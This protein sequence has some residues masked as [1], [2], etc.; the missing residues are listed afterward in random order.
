MKYI[1]DVLDSG[2][3][4]S[5]DFD[6][7]KYVQKLESQIRDFTGAQYAVAV[8]SGTSALYASLAVLDLTGNKIAYPAFTF[9]ATLN[10]ILAHSEL[11]PVP[12]DVFKDNVTIR[13]DNF[14][15]VECA[16]PVH[17]YGHVAYMKQLKET[18]TPFIIEDCC[19]ALGSY[20]DNKHVGLFGDLGC[21][22][23]YPSKI[24]NAGEGGAVITNSKAL[25]DKLKL[26]RNHGKECWG[27]N[28]RLSEIHACLAVEQF[29]NINALLQV[30]RNKAKAWAD[31]FSQSE[32]ITR[33]YSRNGEIRNN[34][35]FTIASP[36]RALIQIEHPSSRIYYDYTLGDKPNANE[37]SK[38]VLSFP[39]G[40]NK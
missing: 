11:Q 40:G 14:P 19:Q 33:F 4:T 30:R 10:A 31:M 34:Q 38:T 7:G 13:T 20:L 32:G 8:N 18:G 2:L 28:L 9:K 22:S 17:L 3:L 23:F 12:V 24:I 6:G 29:E 21:F 36:H 16:I 25:A 15:E 35:S 27:L 26:F 5:S 37:F 39:T 1:Q